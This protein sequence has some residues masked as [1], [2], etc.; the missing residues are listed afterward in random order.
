MTTNHYVDK[1]Q[2]YDDLCAWKIVRD[3][4][5][6][7][8]KTPPALPESVGKAI[9][10]I[11]E[12]TARRPNFRNYTYLEEMKGDGTIQAV[13]A[14]NKF[15]PE[16]LGKNGAVNPFGFIS[17]CVFRAF[18][19][20]ITYEKEKHKNKMKYMLDPTNEFFEQGEEEHQIDTSG[21]NSFFYAN[22]VH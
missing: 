2:L 10:D 9:L 14:M 11:V 17:R 21:L 6:E 5:I 16:R 7:E 1:K 8:N 4:A 18:V 15:D 13:R 12:G 22:K 3:K 20:R 19:N